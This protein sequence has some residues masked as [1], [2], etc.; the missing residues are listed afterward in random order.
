M[1][2]RYTQ[3]W[4]VIKRLEREEKELKSQEVVAENEEKKIRRYSNECNY[5][6]SCR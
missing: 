2:D 6:G 5:S 3:Y 4:N 1:W